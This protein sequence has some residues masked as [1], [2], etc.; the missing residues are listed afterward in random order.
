MSLNYIN[1]DILIRLGATSIG[2]VI[3]PLTLVH[4]TVCVV[5]FAHPIGLAKLPLAIISASVEPLLLTVTVTHT[6]EPLTLVDCTTVKIYRWAE[7][8]N[9][10]RKIHV[11]AYNLTITED[12]LVIA[13][14]TTVF[15]SSTAV[16]VTNTIHVMMIT[17][18]GI[19]IELVLLVLLDGLCECIS[20]NL[21]NSVSRGIFSIAI[22]KESRAVAHFQN[23]NVIN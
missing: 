15:G 17:E 19:P 9:I 4:V 21:P 22:R 10:F 12:T 6:I 7:L 8:T 11:C 1:F 18:S 5:K 3:D 13:Q 2:F 14:I 16:H 20:I 23:L